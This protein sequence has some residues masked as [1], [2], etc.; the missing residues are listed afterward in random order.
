MTLRRRAAVLPPGATS[1]TAP[2]DAGQVLVR[3]IGYLAVLFVAGAAAGA[4][5]LVSLV[6]ETAMR[7]AVVRDL[8]AGALTV[9]GPIW[10]LIG[11]TQSGWTIPVRLALA[12][13]LI[14][15]PTPRA[16]LMQAAVVLWLGTVGLLIAV[17]GG[18]PPVGSVHFLYVVLPSIVYGMAAVLAALIL[19]EV[20]DVR[21][22]DLPW[23]PPALAA[24]LAL[25]YAMASHDV[26]RG[27]VAVAADA[28][29]L[30]AAAGWLGGPAA[31]LLVL[32]AEAPE[33]RA[34]AAQHLMPRLHILAAAS[35]A[36]LVVTGA[37]GAWLHVPA[38]RALVAVPYGRTLLIKLLLVALLLV[39][40]ARR[41]LGVGRRL[42]VSSGDVVP[43]VPAPRAYIPE[44][45][46]AVLILLIVAALTITPPRRIAPSAG[47]R[48][49]ATTG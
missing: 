8:P 20:P 21:L 16:R 19:P 38:V 17:V 29:H 27:P 12:A 7:A 3:W 5:L 34:K 30:L 4:A 36:V 25:A 39:L 9:P 40:G 43:G 24:M 14:L 6:V 48:L 13:L 46:L 11:G 33:R 49:S 15:P 28:V 47:G 37:Y 23:A 41:R 32:G 2:P 45:V 1:R 42:P 10:L 35:L 31:C 18:P 26:G 22:P 44:A